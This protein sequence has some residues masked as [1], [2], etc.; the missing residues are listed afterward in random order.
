MHPRIIALWSLLLGSFSLCGCLGE[1]LQNTRRAQTF[2]SIGV[3]QSNMGQFREALA[4]LKRA[5]ELDSDNYWIQ[6]ALGGNLLRMGQPQLALA[7][8]KKALDNQPKSPR[9]WN[10]LG[11]V[12]MALEQWPQAILAFQNALNNVLYQTPCLAYINIAWCHHKTRNYKESDKYFDMAADS[13]PRI[14]QGHRL[15]GMAAYERKN[16]EQAS[17]SFKHLTTYCKKFLPGYYQLGLTY[18][19]LKQYEEARKTLT[20]CV[21]QSDKMPTVQQSCR[22]LAQN[23]PRPTVSTPASTPPNESSYIYI[24]PHPVEEK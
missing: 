3:K 14:C 9:G 18:V 7:H 16:Y 13:C 12:Y 10:N 6:E 23:L 2:Y 8:F 17:Q 19:A 5:E 15:R 22:Q 4:S 21:E 11:T 24:K 1:R 20:Y